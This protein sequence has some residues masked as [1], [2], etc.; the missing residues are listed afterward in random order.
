VNVVQVLPEAN[1]RQAPAQLLA[2]AHFE[3]LHLQPQVC[4]FIATIST[5]RQRLP[6]HPH[7]NLIPNNTAKM[8]GVSVR[9]VQADKFINSYAAFL[10][11]QGK[12]PIPG[13]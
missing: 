10:K 12:L 8:G 11:R 3:K 5:T 7:T 2:R 1:Y 9:D 4:D 6:S 13:S